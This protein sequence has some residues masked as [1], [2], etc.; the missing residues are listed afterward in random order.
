M[1]SSNLSKRRTARAWP[2]RRPIPRGRFSIESTETRRVWGTSIPTRPA[3]VIIACSCS[4]SPGKAADGNL[5][6]Q[7]PPTPPAGMVSLSLADI[8]A[9]NFGWD[10]GQR[11]AERGERGGHRLESG[12]R[13]ATIPETVP[14]LVGAG[15]DDR[16]LATSDGDDRNGPREI[17]AEGRQQ[18]ELLSRIDSGGPRKVFPQRTL[19]QE[20]RE[21]RRCPGACER[22][23][24][25]QV[26]ERV[27]E[28]EAQGGPLRIV[29]VA[30][31]EGKDDPVAP[32]PGERADRMTV[33][34]DIEDV[35][36]SHPA[37]RRW[38]GPCRSQRGR[39]P[40]RRGR[41]FAKRA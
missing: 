41:T 17:L 25:D 3:S 34:T 7:E 29:R 35:E 28:G 27:L 37:G 9:D 8:A 36:V 19:R 20:I 12:V 38:L 5:T 15:A 6:I 16:I 10:T 32:K 4:G 18:R 33:K 30:G 24:G 11:E 40:G 1:P 26:A 14:A 2:L 39:G 23:V 22:N 31:V 21:E 13:S